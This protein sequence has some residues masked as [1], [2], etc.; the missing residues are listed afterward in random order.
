ML[1]IAAIERV[2]MLNFEQVRCSLQLT[3]HHVGV[4]GIYEDSPGDI[5]SLRPETLLMLEVRDGASR[6]A[7]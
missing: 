5:F 1:A 7:D 6:I 3:R 4:S 2:G